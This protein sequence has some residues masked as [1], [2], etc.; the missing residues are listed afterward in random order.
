MV[1]SITSGHLYFIKTFYFICIIEY[2]LILVLNQMSLANTIF[3]LQFMDCETVSDI[4]TV[5]SLEQF[6]LKHTW[7][8]FVSGSL[9][10]SL[11]VQTFGYSLVGLE[12]FYHIIFVHFVIKL[13]QSTYYIG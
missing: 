13:I 4:H 7:D 12:L 11:H 5:T 9:F 6:H 8:I 2:S 3:T 10:S 1:W